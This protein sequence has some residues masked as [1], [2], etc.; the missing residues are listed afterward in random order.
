MEL[1]IL[2]K[3]RLGLASSKNPEVIKMNMKNS[4]MEN[5]KKL[6]SQYKEE[7]HAVDTMDHSSLTLNPMAGSEIQTCTVQ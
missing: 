3:G 5:H 1:E 4:G 6:G 2:E 7:N